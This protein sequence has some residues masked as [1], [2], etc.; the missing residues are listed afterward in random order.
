MTS[1]AAGVEG[2]VELE[3]KQEELK[4]QLLKLNKAREEMEHDMSDIVD[5]LQSPQP[6]GVVPGLEGNLIDD[7]GF[8]RADMD[9]QLI[10]I[11]RN[12]RAMLQTDH[13]AKMKEIEALLLQIHEVYGKLAKLSPVTAVSAPCNS[14]E[15]VE[16]VEV[17]VAPESISQ[18][19]AVVHEVTPLSPGEKAGLE[20]GD[21]ILQVGTVTRG[22]GGITELHRVGAYLQENENKT[23]V[24]IALRGTK[25]LKMRLVPSKWSGNGLLGCHLVPS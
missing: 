10:R 18:P 3:E 17:D 22:I 24:L 21:K 19:F 1:V 25:Q 6:S 8:P 5:F 15:T 9:I 23:V 12:K 11:Q 13:K 20:V 4:Q 14:G 7:E 16:S 2:R